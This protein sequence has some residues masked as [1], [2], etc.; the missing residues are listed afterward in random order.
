MAA[1]C[2]GVAAAVPETTLL[3]THISRMLPLHESLG[4]LD[5]AAIFVDANV[6]RWA[7]RT[8]DLPPQYQ[9]ADE[10]LKL[11][12]RVVMPGMVKSHQHTC[13]K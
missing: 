5:D 3:L 9:A 13:A 11:S 6:I 10:V 4:E 7:G 1:P 12:D 8:A 2:A